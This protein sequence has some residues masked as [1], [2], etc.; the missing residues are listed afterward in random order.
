MELG[1]GYWKKQNIKRFQGCW[2]LD[3]QIA[4]APAGGMVEDLHVLKLLHL[5]RFHPFTFCHRPP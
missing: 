2:N 5:R 1:Y 4:A 3:A